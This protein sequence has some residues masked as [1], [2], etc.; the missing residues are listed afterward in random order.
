MVVVAHGQLS[1]VVFCMQF[2]VKLAVLCNCVASIKGNAI[3]VE[4]PR[5]FVRVDTMRE[6]GSAV[7]LLNGLA[8]EIAPLNGLALDGAWRAFIGSLLDVHD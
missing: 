5:L 1:L 2:Y 8:L 3:F 4:L 6:S 7:A